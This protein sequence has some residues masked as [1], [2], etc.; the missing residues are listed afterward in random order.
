MSIET[1]QDQVAKL[2]IAFFGRAPDAIG[3]NYWVS[4][5]GN[6]V[7]LASVAASF[8]RQP[9]FESVYGQASAQEVISLLYQQTLNRSVDQAGLSYWRE[10]LD[11]GMSLHEIANTI[12]STAYTGG[13]TVSES[14]TALVRNKV[15][16]AKYVSIELGLDAP[17]LLVSLLDEVTADAASVAA[18]QSSAQSALLELQQ[19]QVAMLYIA[20]FG[21]APD[22]SGYDHWLEA[23]STGVML[24]EV[25]SDFDQAK[26]FEAVYGG[27][28]TSEAIDLLYR[29]TFNR[30]VDAGG[31]AYWQQQVEQGISFGEVAKTIVTAAYR[32]GEGV[33]AQD[34]ALLTNKVAVAKYAALVLGLEEPLWL[35][36]AFDGVTA[37]PASVDAAIVRLIALAN[38]GIQFD[39]PPR[40]APVLTDDSDSSVPIRPSPI[41]GTPGPDSLTGTS[42]NDTIDGLAGDDTIDGAAGNDSIIGT[43][44]AD[45]I[46]GG[47]GA[48]SLDGGDGVDRV[49]YSDIDSATSHGLSNITGMAINLSATAV[50]A[51]AIETAM[52]GTIVLG[53]GEQ[54]AGVDLVAGSA[55][56]LAAAAEVS[57][58]D[59]VRDSLSNF[60]AIIGSELSDYLVL[61]DSGMLVEALA[62]SD[63]ILGGAGDD[64]IA[65]GGGADAINAGSG[66]NVITDAGLETDTIVHDSVSSTVSIDVTHSGSVLLSAAQEG[67]IATAV[68]DTTTNRHI[69]ASASTAAVTLDVSL[70]T[71]GFATLVGGAGNDTLTGGAGMD[72]ITG[73]AGVDSLTGGDGDDVFLI[74]ARAR[75]KPLPPPHHGDGEVIQG[76]AG[77]DTIRFISTASLDL[78][79]VSSDVSVEIIEL[80]DADGLN[81]GVATTSIDASS[82]ASSEHVSLVGNDGANKLTGNGGNNTILGGGGNDTIR[83]GVGNDLL[84]GGAGSEDFYIDLGASGVDTITDFEVLGDDVIL[85]STNLKDRGGVTVTSLDIT[86]LNFDSIDNIDAGTQSLGDGDVIVEV[87]TVNRFGFDSG[88]SINLDVA[89]STAA[90]IVAQA[91]AVFAGNYWGGDAQAPYI[92]S[93][94]SEEL[95]FVF[96]EAPA[97]GDTQDAVLIR[98]K[99]D[100]VSD[101]FSGEL[102]L[103]VV[104]L[105]VAADSLSEMNFTDTFAI[106]LP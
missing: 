51:E 50:T 61:G 98:A 37:D 85:E 105:N 12:V 80:S 56:Y 45:V 5:L 31:L 84:T 70:L 79:T 94:N 30:R 15:T 9:E 32:G 99:G 60:E 48:D 26:E 11:Q 2:Y 58:T 91:Q 75:V 102:T 41:L 100:G 49:N 69:D 86:N 55:G 39:E 59:M 92:E 43:S 65:G 33:D 103:H 106:S 97:K 78:L 64:T 93:A 53:G 36:I 101:S 38:G 6:G 66:S 72:I 3:L 22:A 52:G 1:A 16:V 40:D 20:M 89:T 13:N 68:G 96:Y 90:D 44:G 77:V 17:T 57:T 46:G 73:G 34:R 87:L 7:D 10:Q 4:Q 29:N 74:D 14:D 54:V 95:L 35:V 76:G 27:R 18:A 21:R 24:Q 47:A 62:G 71:A 81:S 28:E 67:V 8:A 82:M 88:L 63:H 83:G 19:D 23:M 104:L 42:G 25:V